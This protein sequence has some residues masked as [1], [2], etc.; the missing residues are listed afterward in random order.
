MRPTRMQNNAI[1]QEPDHLNRMLIPLAQW[2]DHIPKSDQSILTFQLEAI[3]NE[4]ENK[5]FFHQ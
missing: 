2:V 1:S 3:F 5:D 4:K